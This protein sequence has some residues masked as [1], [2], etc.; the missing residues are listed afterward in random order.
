M[1]Y[2]MC[3]MWYVTLL[4]RFFYDSVFMSQRET[5]N[6]A[7]GEFKGVWVAIHNQT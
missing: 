6:V 7:Y 5:K 1:G 3:G 4:T 2:M